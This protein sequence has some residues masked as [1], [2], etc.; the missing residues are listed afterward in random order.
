MS[1]SAADSVYLWWRKKGKKRAIYDVICFS[2][3]LLLTVSLSP[4]L[5]PP[6]VRSSPSLLL[7]LFS[8]QT[9]PMCSLPGKGGISPEPGS[10]PMWLIELK[11]SSMIAHWN[12]H[13][14]ILTA[15]CPKESLS[16]ANWQWYRLQVLLE[17]H[18]NCQNHIL[19]GGQREGRH[20]WI[21]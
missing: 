2:M 16:S 7:P 9:L 10:L 11:F 17:G 13:R 8:P 1:L 6:P 12:S 3:P 15:L 18:Q 21:K 19:F 5:F 20:F 14:I 4:C